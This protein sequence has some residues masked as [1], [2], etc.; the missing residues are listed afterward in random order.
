MRSIGS[1]RISGEDSLD[2]ILS[3]TDL[4]ADFDYLSID[5]DGNDYYVW[6]SLVNYRPKAVVIEYNPTVPSEVVWVQENNPLTRQGAGV[7]SIVELGKRKGY[8]LVALGRF[9]AFFVRQEYFAGLGIGDNSIA[10]LRQDQKHV[11]HIWSGFD[12]TTFTTG[13]G[14]LPWHG[15][16]LRAGNRQELPRFLRKYFWDY[17]LFQ[18]V[19]FILYFAVRAPRR[20]AW[21][22]FQL[23]KIKFGRSGQELTP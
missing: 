21:S 5:I 7:R 9:N 2:G 10:R 6:E 23:A 12:G 14:T 18:K 11:T 19:V 1:S 22:L 20:L 13:G 15:I 8:E 3:E 17:S 16:P 4:P